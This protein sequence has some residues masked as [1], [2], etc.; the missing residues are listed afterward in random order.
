VNELKKQGS[1]DKERVAD[2]YKKKIQDLFKEYYPRSD[3]KDRLIIPRSFA[4]S[5]NAYF[6]AKI[7]TA[8]EIPVYIDDVLEDDVA[9]AQPYFNI[10]T[11]APNI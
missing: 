5:E 8:L 2:L 10:D 7:F 11:C 4:V 1:G 3:A 9:I 6:I